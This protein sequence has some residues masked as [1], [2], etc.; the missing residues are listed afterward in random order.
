MRVTPVFCDV[1]DQP[2]TLL[3]YTKDA[4]R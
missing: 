3:R 4:G 1:P 2:I